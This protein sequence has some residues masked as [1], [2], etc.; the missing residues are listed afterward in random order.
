M[1][2]TIARTLVVAACLAA[3]AARAQDWT[4][5]R[6][7]RSL[8]LLG[9]SLAQGGSGLENYE[10]GTSTY[11]MSMEFRSMVRQR[12]SVGLAFDSNRFDDTKSL[13][14]QVLPAGG[15][16]SGPTYRYAHEFAIKVTGHGYLMDGPLRPYVGVGLGGDWNYAYVQSAD[17]ASTKDNFNFIVTPEVGVT[18][19]A[20]S[21]ASS[22]GLNLSVRY[23][24]STAAVPGA[25][26][27][28]WWSEVIGIVASY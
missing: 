21:G 26:D 20:V 13:E 27:V 15:T 22:V 1:N 6:P 5:Y 2:K 8:F 7:D 18:W 10:S 14:T 24:Y 12:F 28:Q 23:N 16:I 9:W 25:S 19:M 17:L 3:P 11:G 4:T